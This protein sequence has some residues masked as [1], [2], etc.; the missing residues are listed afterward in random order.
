MKSRLLFGDMKKILIIENQTSTRNLF[1]EN[2][3]AK[4]FDTID[5]EDGLIGM[6]LAKEQLPDLI[7][8]EI[9]IPTLDGISILKNL[10]QNSVTAAMPMIFV[11]EQGS[12]A[13]IRKAMELGADDYITKPCQV[14]ELLR[15]IATCLTK[16]DILRQ[17]FIVQHE[18]LSETQLSKIQNTVQ[19]DC[20][21][22]EVFQFIETNYCHPISL[23]DVATAVGYSAAYLTNFVRNKTGQSIQQWIIQ[24]RMIAARTLLLET[25]ETVVCIAA[26]VG[27]HHTAHFCRQFRQH[28]DKTPQTWRKEQLS[29]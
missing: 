1:V 13:D 11:S 2:L 15:A 21:L 20:K 17:E 3:Q 7:V 5:T 29:R 28:H 12:R 19:S 16:R 23:S 25:D 14:D 22:K 4:G 18:N 6:H 10:R 9:R 26:K 8:S 27:Y 24:Y